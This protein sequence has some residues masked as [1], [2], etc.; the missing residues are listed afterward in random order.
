MAFI[1]KEE[2]RG[3]SLPGLIDIIFL[4][5]IFCLGTLTTSESRVEEEGGSEGEADL[6][7]PETSIKRTYDVDEVLQTLLL[8]VDLT[9]PNDRSSPKRIMILWPSL[10]DSLTIEEAKSNAMRDSLF[11][12]FP[13]NLLS[14]SDRDFSRTPPCTLI[15]WGLETYKNDYFREPKSSNTIEI[16]AVRDTEFRIINFILEQCSVYGDTIPRLTLRTM[17]RQEGRRGF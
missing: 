16:R 15:H 4:L 17:S 8:Q 7:L 13:P 5:L 12:V 10:E 14:L 6:N 11:A 1:K 9:D 2:K 3:L